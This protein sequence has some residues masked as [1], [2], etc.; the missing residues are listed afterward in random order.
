MT[1][2]RRCER[3]I[4][5][6]DHPHR[7]IENAWFK[8]I[9]NRLTQDKLIAMKII[10]KK[11]HTRLVNETWGPALKKRNQDLPQDWIS[12]NE[13]FLVGMKPWD[14]PGLEPHTTPTGCA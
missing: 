3:T 10:R 1:W 14:N 13:V 2:T 6:T 12:Q 4:Q 11:K 9:N 5:G 8:V 7:E